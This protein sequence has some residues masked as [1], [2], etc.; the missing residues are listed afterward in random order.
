VREINTTT[1]RNYVRERAGAP[2]VFDGAYLGL[3]C[4]TGA[5]IAAGQLTGHA[6]FFWN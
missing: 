2:R 5:T 4:C 3:L 1:E 6:K